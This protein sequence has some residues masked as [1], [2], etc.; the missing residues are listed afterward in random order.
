MP[1][2]A[3]ALVLLSVEELAV[4]ELRETFHRWVRTVVFPVRDGELGAPLPHAPAVGQRRVNG[5]FGPGLRQVAADTLLD[6]TRALQTWIR[7]YAAQL[8]ESLE[9]QLDIDNQTAQQRENERY[10]QRNGE[11]ST[12]INQSTVDRLEREIAE[13]QNRQRQGQLFDETERLADIHQSIDAKREEI[14]RR[15]HHY[16]EIRAQLQR[17]R[18]RILD[19]LLPKRHA[20]AGSAHVFPVAIEVRLPE[21]SR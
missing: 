11:L 18:T 14:E 8:T 3:D 9:D 16:E 12:L 15:Q 4:N 10:R 19:Q 6:T 2:G 13:L 5:A 17:E 1:P 20:L 7:T 21:S